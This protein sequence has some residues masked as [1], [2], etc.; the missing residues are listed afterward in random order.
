MLLIETTDAD[1][2][3]LIEGVAPRG[4]RQPS[5]GMERPEVL[6][7]LRQLATEIRPIF[8][9]A[10]WMMVEEGEIVGLCSIVKLP[11]DEGVFI[12][13]GVAPERRLLGFASAGVR[14]LLEWARNDGR[15][16]V[17]R[18]E[19]SVHNRPSQRV[20][21]RNGFKRTGARVDE[22]DGDLICWSLAVSEQLSSNVEQSR[23]TSP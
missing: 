13:Y 21:E 5:G 23:Q 11:S 15:V 6:A 3:D 2:G 10:S 19:T 4:L 9:P 7:M 22:E 8:R 16:D 20:L 1:F 14:A 12:G 17:I 18:A